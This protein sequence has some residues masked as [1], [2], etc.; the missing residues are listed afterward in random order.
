MSTT[1]SAWL[2]GIIDG[3][4]YVGVILA[5]QRRNSGALYYKPD[6][7]VS[8]THEETI[9]KLCNFTDT[10]MY[11]KPKPKDRPNSLQAYD[12]HCP[13]SVMLDL[14]TQIRPYSVTKRKNIDLLISFLMLRTLDIRDRDYEQSIAEELRALTRTIRQRKINNVGQNSAPI[15]P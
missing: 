4:G 14:L 7:T 15:G 10:K 5:K 1:E 9:Q 6:V 2:A 13:V 8:M 11:Q 3:E 12:W